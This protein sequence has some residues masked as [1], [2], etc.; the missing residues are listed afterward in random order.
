MMVN[1][2]GRFC[3]NRGCPDYG[4]KDEGNIVGFGHDKNGRQ[5]Y[6]CQTCRRVFV[7]TRNTIFY[8]RK[9]PEDKIIMI[10]KL[11]VEK[12]G[13]RAISRIM[14]IHRDT[15][16]SIVEDLAK[17]CREITQFLIQDVK[18]T[19]CEVDEMWTFVKKQKRLSEEIKQE[20][21]KVIFGYG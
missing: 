12:N 10:C 4:K 2:K 17:H 11:L 18:L 6:R 8:Y 21:D 3:S 13:I 15:V 20:I 5:R 16:M 14:D 9:L 19:K 7:E 1:T